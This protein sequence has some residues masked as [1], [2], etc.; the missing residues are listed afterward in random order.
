[1]EEEF[2]TRAYEP[3][4]ES[5]IL[6]LFHKVFHTG[7]TLAHWRWKYLENPRRNRCIS[8]T[9]SP[10]GELVAHYAGYGSRWIDGRHSKPRILETLQIGDTMTA[11]GFRH[12]GRGPTSLLGRT[13]AHF[14]ATFCADRVAFNYGFN[15]ANIRKFSL[16]FVNA[17]R[18]EDVGSWSCDPP[19][20]LGGRRFPFS[21]YRAAPFDSVDGRW[22][23]LFDRATPG[24]A[25]L[26][27][28]DAEAVRWR[29]LSCP[30]PGLRRW[31]A[32][33][34]SRLAAWAVFR[35]DREDLVWGDAL[36]DP[37]HP[38]AARELLRAALAHEQPAPASL[39]AWFPPRPSRW[40]RWL[41]DHGFRRRPEPNDLAVMCVPFLEPEC[42]EMLR[43]SYY[44]QGDGDLF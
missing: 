34:G 37:E 36:V 19:H 21:R 41:E 25:V 33:R 20:R 31:A 6:G 4:D 16:R 7:R 13:V 26:A 1:V 42:E 24:Y 30:D 2:Q 5:A 12:V 14:Y 32:W 3:G 29:Y 38:G 39:T 43:A 27:G 23:E 15:T 8:L 10:A 28:R 44:T 11:P 22:D 9:F 17:R 40:A 18:A 35:R